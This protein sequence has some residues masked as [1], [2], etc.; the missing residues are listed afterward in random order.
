MTQVSPDH[1]EQQDVPA[2]SRHGRWL[3]LFMLVM[4]AAVTGWWL[5]GQPAKAPAPVAKIKVQVTQ[6]EVR[7]MPVV[8]QSV[9]KVVAQASVE[10]RAQTNGVLRQVFIKDG[11]RVVVG[12]KLF[13]LET[14]PLAAALVQ[15]QSQ[16]ARDKALADDAAAAQARLK[17]LAE[18]EYVTAR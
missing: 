11:E 15:A 10:V 5:Y 6:A 9:G 14:Q 16:W 7:A 2:A 12:Q 4:L 8:L 13:A 18:K 17:P 1:A 3:A